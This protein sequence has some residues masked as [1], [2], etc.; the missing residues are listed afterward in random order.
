M[1]KF[2]KSTLLGIESF[3]PLERSSTPYT[4]KF[5]SI[6]LEA[7]FDPINPATPVIKTFLITLI[8]IFLLLY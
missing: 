2:I 4:L 1:S 3:F 8:L 7:I 5:S 6:N